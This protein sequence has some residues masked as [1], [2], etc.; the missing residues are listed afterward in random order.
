ML[1]ASLT[2]WPQ[3][4]G[5]TAVSLGENFGG[6]RDGHV[7]REGVE[8][9]FTASFG[10]TW[11]DMRLPDSDQPLAFGAV[12]GNSG[13]VFHFR[14]RTLCNN[15]IIFARIEFRIVLFLTATSTTAPCCGYSLW[16]E[17]VFL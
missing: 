14:V 8:M 17:S 13:K 11:T 9:S 3:L 2:F 10:G 6:E 12:V 15:S 16:T 1:L 5:R 7:G 4:E